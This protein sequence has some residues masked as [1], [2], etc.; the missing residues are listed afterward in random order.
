MKLPESSH[1]RSW[2]LVPHE[3]SGLRHDSEE[4]HVGYAVGS[5]FDEDETYPAT[6]SLQNDTFLADLRRLP[7]AGV[8]YDGVWVALI[9]SRHGWP[10]LPF[11]AT[12]LRH[13]RAGRRSTDATT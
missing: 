5:R 13:N 8:R 12:V 1:Y 10:T 2:R 7:D 6:A 11:V 3:V 4:V 9:W